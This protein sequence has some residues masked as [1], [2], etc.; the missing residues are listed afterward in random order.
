MNANDAESRYYLRSGGGT[1]S[2][3]QC[4]PWE[5]KLP[6]EIYFQDDPNSNWMISAIPTV[7]SVRGLPRSKK[8]KEN[9]TEA[10][11]KRERQQVVFWNSDASDAFIRSNK[12]LA[13][14]KELVE[15]LT[16]AD[17][18]VVIARYPWRVTVTNPEVKDPQSEKWLKLL[19]SSNGATSIDLWPYLYSSQKQASQFIPAD[20]H[21]NPAG[22]ETIARAIT[23]TLSKSLQ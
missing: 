22:S 7:L 17:I 3:F 10:Y 5:A 18:K 12:V 6:P 20:G 13:A 21:P 2:R 11:E 15:E 4:Y 23:M 9:D 1:V 16:S 14:G 19:E 8:K